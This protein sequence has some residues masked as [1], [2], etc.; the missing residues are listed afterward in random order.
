MTSPLPPYDYDSKDPYLNRLYTAMQYNPET[1][2]PELRVNVGASTITITGPVTI[3]GT[4]TVNSTPAD[5]VH[6]HVSEVGTSGVLSVPYMPSGIVDGT[7]HINDNTHPVYVDITNGT[8]DVVQSGTWNV[9]I[10][11]T[12]TVNIGTMPEVEIKNDSGNPI[13]VTATISNTPSVA[14]IPSATDAFGRLRVSQPFTLFDTQSRY[15][16]HGQFS[17]ATVNGA[18][19]NYQ[20]NSS[21]YTLTVGTSSGSSVIQETMKVFP[22]QPGKS[23]LVLNS[24]CMNSTIPGVTQRVGFFGAQNGIFFEAAGTTLNMVIRSYSSGIVTEDRI[25]QDQWNGDRLDGNGGLTNVSNITLHPDRDQI[26][27][28][29]IEWLG[30]GSVRCG[31]VIDGQT[32]ICHTFNHANVIGNT[33]TYMTTATL[34]IRYEIFN[35]S[36]QASNRTMRQICSTVISE[37]GYTQFGPLSSAGT[38]INV[39]RLTTGGTYYPIASIRL[40]SSRLDSIVSPVQVDILSPSVNYYR[41]ALLKNAILTG[42]TWSGTSSTGTV[43]YDTSATGVS[44][45]IE[46]ESGYV[47]S[48]DLASLSSLFFQLQLGRTLAGVSDT[49]TL[50][51]TATSNN[52]D[53]LAQLAWQE[54]T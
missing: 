34:P 46:V 53:V 37:G 47:S 48:R 42:A 52:A 27:Y 2:E 4:V 26:F 11:G 12:P 49:C 7:G 51:M 10:T 16:D 41:W 31:F 6:V 25:P 3:P 33:T 9:G 17:T 28:T 30:V 1:G 29:D 20:A 21:T 54:L 32:Y 24:F 35:T 5:P 40:A 39:L 8:L 14:F 19:V 22:Y 13:S 23:L 38:G 44:G 50:V 45:G 18:S 36:A 15:Y 43:Q